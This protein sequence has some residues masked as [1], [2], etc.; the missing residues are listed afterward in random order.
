MG[1]DVVIQGLIA[2]TILFWV[3]K[4]ILHYRRLILYHRWYAAHLFFLAHL[5]WIKE[6]NIPDYIN[7]FK[8]NLLSCVLLSPPVSCA[9]DQQMYEES[10]DHIRNLYIMTMQGKID[11]NDLHKVVEN[12]ER[13]S[14]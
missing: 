4:S 1:G 9:V 5:K 10:I 13:M 2:G 3:I 6:A 8:P 7:N 11:L 14:R 12:A